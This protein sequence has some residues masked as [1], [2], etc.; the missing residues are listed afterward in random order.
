MI[1]YW[2]LKYILYNTFTRKNLVAAYY[3]GGSLGILFTI[4]IL[5]ILMLT[6]FLGKTVMILAIVLLITIDTYIT[7]SDEKVWSKYRY[8]EQNRDKL[9]REFRQVYWFIFLDLLFFVLTIIY[10]VIRRG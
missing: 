1:Q 8:I 10:V 6:G 9:S 7:W 4:P 5:S 2:I 3:E